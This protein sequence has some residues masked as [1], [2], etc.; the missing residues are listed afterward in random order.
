M[1]GNPPYIEAKKLKHIASSLK[2]YYKVCSGT[3]DFSIYFSELALN[4]LRNDGT[5]CFITTNK[6]FNT[7]YGE[8]IRAI[9]AAK[10]IHRIINFEQVE[11]FK[12]ILVSS[13]IIEIGNSVNNPDNRFVYEK[14]Y[15][16]N[17]DEFKEQFLRRMGTFGE[18][19]QKYID[20][21]EWSFANIE[22]LALKT[23][24]EEAA[25]CLSDIQGVN[26]Y[27]GI[28]TGYNPAF[29][30]SSEQKSRLVSKNTSNGAIIKNML[31]GRNIRKW[32]FNEGEEYLLQ[33]GYDTDIPKLYPDI[34]SHLL[35]HY[36]P[37][38]SRSDQG[39]NW[40]NLRACQYYPSFEA[41]SKIVWGLTADK[42]AFALDNEQ[43]YLPSNAYILTSSEIPIEYIL[44]LLNSKLLKYYFGFI[45]VMTA[46]GAYTLK[47]ATISALPFIIADENIVSTISGLVNEILKIKI[48]DHDADVSILESQIDSLVYQIYGLTQ[49]EITLV[50]C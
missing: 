37:M 20:S 16:L 48:E 8:K 26:I 2:G 7:E 28:T 27:R 47:A 14:F 39:K 45:G 22:E 40:W 24:I 21:R 18:Y 34:Y 3:A 42:W 50:E 49:S 38:V 23:H 43:H 5:M 36:E 15:K 30:I 35:E 25:T 1:I 32:F 19:P 13:V 10:D 6:F 46:G 41:P 12:D 17:K 4:L 29:I 9:F 33:T 44:G 11:V 31:Q